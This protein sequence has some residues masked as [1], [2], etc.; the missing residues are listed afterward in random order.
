MSGLHVAL[1]DNLTSLW[2]YLAYGLMYIMLQ[3]LICMFF[4]CI[5]KWS[6]LAALLAGVVIGEMTLGGGVTLHLDNLPQWYQTLSPLQWTLTVL[7][8]QIYN[9]DTLNK[10]N[11]KAKQI[12]RQ[13]IIVQAPCEQPD[14]AA[15]L[16]EISLHN[17]ND[18]TD[19]QMGIGIGI[20]IVL[21]IMGF[22]CIR[23]TTRKRARS[24]PNK[25]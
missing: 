5:C 14:G 7:L 4:A 15:A 22:L 9:S 11:C 24:A 21:I 18:M 12:Q 10:T 20:I 6:G 17:V 19:I 13:D 3:H 16:R 2:N 1:D 8:P 25:P 23:Y